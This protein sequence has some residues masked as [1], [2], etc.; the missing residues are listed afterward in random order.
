[1]GHST[2]AVAVARRNVCRLAVG[3]VSAAL[4]AVGAPAVGVLS[5]AAPASAATSGASLV[6]K[7][8]NRPAVPAGAFLLGR[9]APA[10]EIVGDVALRPRDAA[11][12]TAYATA[13][14]TPGS[15]LYHDYLTAAGFDARFAPSPSTI[16]AVEAQLRAGGLRITS[17]S[18]DGL[19]VGFKGSAT[20]AEDTFHTAI[21]QY[22]LSS[23]RTV[24]A[25]SRKL[26]WSHGATKKVIGACRVDGRAVNTVAD[27]D[28]V[29]AEVT[30][31]VQRRR[32]ATRWQNMTSRTGAPT[33]SDRGPIEIAIGEW[34]PMVRGALDWR[35]TV[36]PGL[37]RQLEELGV[38]APPAA[39]GADVARFA[40]T[41]RTLV[42]RT[43]LVEI[44]RELGA[45]RDRLQI[46]AAA[47]SASPLWRK[48]V[49]AFDG[50]ADDTWDRLRDE[51]SR[52][53]QLREAAA[54]R[55]TLLAR[56]A[57]AAPNLA[58]AV[59]AA[60]RT[61]DPTLF[62][63]SWAWRQVDV[64]LDD[65]DEGPEPRDLQ[66]QLEQLSKDIRRLTTDL[67]AARA[68]AA[69]AESIDDRRRQA[70]NRFT[71]ANAK[72]GK[73]TGRYA[74]RWEA[75]LRA[76]MDDAKD[77][78]PVW[79]MPIHK[80]LSSFL[81]NA[82]PP[83][84]VIVV[85]EASQV[86][87]LQTPVLALAKRAIV[88]GDDQQTSPENVGQL[89]VR[90]HELID[91]HLGAV[92]DRK[93][94]FD[95]NNSLYDLARQQFPQ[96]VQL[97]EHFRCLPRIIEFSNH[98]WYN[99]TIVPLRDRPPRPG[100]QPLGTVF[101]PTGSRRGAGQVNVDEASA[102][103]DLMAEL[104][105]DPDYEGMTFG[106]ISLLATSGQ[107]KYL[108]DQV[109]DNFGPEVIDQR[110][111]RVGDPA[112][113]QGDERDVVILSM[114]VSN[115]IDGRIGAMNTPAAGRRINVAASRAQ[116]QLWVVHSVGPEALHPDDPR[117]ALLEHCLMPSDDEV[118][119]TAF[120]KSESQFERDVLQRILD[121]GYTRVVSQYPVGGYRID[122]VVEGPEGRRL[123]V[124]CDGDRWH[125]PDAWDHDRA[126]QMVLER[127]G[128][129]FE[130]IRGSAFYRDRNLALEP[131][132]RRLDELGIPK[133][134]WMGITKNTVM[135]RT[136]PGDFE[137]DAWVPLH[138]TPELNGE[139][140]G[141]NTELASN[142]GRPGGR[143]TAATFTKRVRSSEDRF[144]ER[145]TVAPTSREIREWARQRGMTVGER[146]RL[147]PDVLAA[148]NRAFPQ[149]PA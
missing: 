49:D 123:A 75:E 108:W 26:G 144:N 77:A 14:S 113:F 116:N 102:V 45:H 86:S 91:T 8:A 27:V 93:T 71:M 60:E 40:E 10:S 4:L 146:G 89:Q 13:V 121:A 38:A 55:Q 16:A 20:Q 74:S 58:A 85:D 6:V 88:V 136:W 101:V 41:C 59:E 148:W 2:R 133:G 94:R 82:E 132:W 79:I 149:R 122:I 84:D 34:L 97:R 127:A 72:I 35:D 131:L 28:L 63:A 92:R 104:L 115:E 15:S 87:L 81:P 43:R 19:L 114:V 99:D 5:N 90:V 37:H 138:V 31:R 103:I 39:D 107:N 64:W 33:L 137:R 30:R 18:R 17:V 100:W 66:A 52:L 3:A 143:Q 120:D 142:D 96:V 24:F 110:R 109:V 124:E 44:E 70:L 11:G 112:S 7:I 22:R 61:V 80:V 106:V 46:A 9:V 117:R 78:V 125:G 21:E 139:D 73:G 105:R 23:G 140:G 126:R 111:I 145:A 98:R 67:V 51:G 47:P 135:R 69:V 29:M 65:L 118:A 36:W 50:A 83:F 147:H 119:Q 12:L 95:Q 53:L 128:W 42:A 48:F 129:T 68:W 57:A 25:N 54:R 56:L 134:D 32:L 1:M 76:A 62:A 141:P 130:R